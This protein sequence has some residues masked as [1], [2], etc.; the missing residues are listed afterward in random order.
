LHQPTS[1]RLIAEYDVLCY[2]HEHGVPVSV[3]LMT[4][5]QCCYAEVSGQIFTLSPEIHVT[6]DWHETKNVM[7]Y[8]YI[9]RSL[10]NFHKILASYPKPIPSWT[11]NLPQQLETEIFPLLESQLSPPYMVALQEKLNLIKP[12]IYTAWSQL[13]T[14]HIHGDCHGGNILFDGKEVRGFIDF[15]HLPIG[16]HVYDISYFLADEV[17]TRIGS[18]KALAD[19]L[20]SFS[21]IIVGYIQEMSLTALE[22]DMLWYGML[23]TQLMFIYWFVKNGNQEHTDK[24]LSVFNWIYQHKLAITT[25]I[26][27]TGDTKQL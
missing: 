4:D 5:D 17:K 24:N 11:M 25:A 13:P 1:E 8:T 12:I 2:L 16:A 23:I 22:K 18:D 3:P 7:R 27:Q 26:A 6:N 15:D 20:T 19:W 21:Y 10:G 14:Q 9:G